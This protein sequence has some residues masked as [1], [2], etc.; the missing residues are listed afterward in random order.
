MRKIIFDTD[1]GVDDCSALLLAH[2]HPGIELCAVTTVFGNASIDDVTRNA[3]YLKDVFGFD[4]P[5]ARG[6]GRPIS[7]A[8]PSAPPAHIHGVNG[9]GDVEIAAQIRATPDPR[10]AHRL[11]IDLLRADPGK[12]TIVAVGRM[13][14]LALALEEAPE[15][16][17]LVDEVV[18]MGGAFGFAGPNGNISPVAEANI[19]GDAQAADRVFTAGWRVRAI[20]LDVTRQICMTPGEFGLLAA[21]ADPAA[22]LVAAASQGYIGFHRDFGVSGCYMHDAAAVAYVID[23]TLFGMR[24]GMVRVSSEGI[25]VGQ[26]VM[27]DPAVPYPP[28]AWDDLPLQYGAESVD[29][30]AVLALILSTLIGGEG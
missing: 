15:I 24:Q 9:L 11:I 12:I 20:G 14:N 13:T 27:R 17:D 5:V 3:L 6:A 19:F 7:G 22:Q 23:P 29:A 4:A 26:T 30:A 18:I 25:T 28:G 2:R 8:E 10:P 21:S 16:V 1:P